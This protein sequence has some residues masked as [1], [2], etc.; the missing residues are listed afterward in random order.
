[1]VEASGSF[2]SLQKPSLILDLGFVNAIQYLQDRT[3]PRSID[4]VRAAFAD[5]TWQNLEVWTTL[6]TKLQDIMLAKGDNSFN[7]P[8]LE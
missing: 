4:A 3:T 1:M 5:V 8:Q 7:F 6:Q 2:T